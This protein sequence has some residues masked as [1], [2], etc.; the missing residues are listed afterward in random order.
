MLTGLDIFLYVIFHAAGGVQAGI[1]NI[2]TNSVQE[3]E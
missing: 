1:Y 3:L 2:S